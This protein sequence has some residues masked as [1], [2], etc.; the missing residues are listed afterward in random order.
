MDCNNSGYFCKLPILFVGWIFPFNLKSVKSKVLLQFQIREFFWE[1]LM[2]SCTSLV[3][4]FGGVCKRRKI[5]ECKR[6]KWKSSKKFRQW[7]TGC[8]IGRS[9][10]RSEW[11]WIQWGLY[12]QC[13]GLPG[14][15]FTAL[16]LWIQL[17]AYKQWL[18][19]LTLGQI[20]LWFSQGWIIF[21]TV[22]CFSVLPDTF[23]L[24]F[25]A[26]IKSFFFFC[27]GGRVKISEEL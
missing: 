26:C 18:A 17:I 14:F 8:Q 24:C 22:F 6:A 19:L 9:E 11:I 13:S 15:P 23:I 1:R 2:R 16:S 21:I 27:G 5:S 7:K 10:Y 25:Y 20:Y 3:D 4:E 12:L